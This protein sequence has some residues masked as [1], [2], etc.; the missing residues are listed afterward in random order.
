[1][2]VDPFTIIV[3]FDVPVLDINFDAGLFRV[4]GDTTGA[5]TKTRSILKSSATTTRCVCRVRLGWRWPVT[6]WPSP[7]IWN[8]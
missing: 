4:A 3:T 2:I 8:S 7:A 6:T 1:M 5:A